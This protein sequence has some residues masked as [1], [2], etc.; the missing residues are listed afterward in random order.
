MTGRL[1]IDAGPGVD[2]VD[3]RSSAFDLFFAFLGDD[4]DRLTV[5]ANLSRLET[6]LDGGPA[7]ADRLIDLGNNFGAYRSRG[8]E[9]SS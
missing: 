7:S 1:Y 8:F 6:D 3:V 9:V 5:F 2:N 4:D